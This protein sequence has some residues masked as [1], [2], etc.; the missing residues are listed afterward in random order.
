MAYFEPSQT[1]FSLT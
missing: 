1:K